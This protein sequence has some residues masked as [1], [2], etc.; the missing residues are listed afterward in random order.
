MRGFYNVGNTCYFNAAL[1]CILRAKPLVDTIMSS[2]YEGDCQFTHE[3][4]KI[5]A[6]YVQDATDPIDN[7]HLLVAFFYAFPMFKNLEQHDAQEALLCMIDILEKAIP[8]IK[9]MV[10]GK[11]SQETVFPGGKKEKESQFCLHI[12]DTK[13]HVLDKAL[14]KSFAWNVLEDYRDDA[15]KTHHVAT[16]REIIKEVAPVFFISFDAKSRVQLLDGLNIGYELVASAT[17]V[18]SQFGG[19]YA[20][21]VKQNDAWFLIDDHSVNPCP[22]PSECGHY[23]LTYTLKTHPS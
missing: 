21:Y 19:H 23:I 14:E 6:S 16:T 5:H 18:G 12:L 22:F 10:Y 1:H 20:S 13:Q 8:A 9:P 2:S 3:F 7:R 11:K 17:H 4:R 15:G